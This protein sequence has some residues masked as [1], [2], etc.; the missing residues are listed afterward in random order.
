MG[1]SAEIL[2]ADGNAD[3]DFRFLG[4]RTVD[5]LGEPWAL[6]ARFLSR[7][8]AELSPNCRIRWS[9]GSSDGSWTWDGVATSVVSR[10]FD[11]TTMQHQVEAL[12]F[13]HSCLHTPRRRVVQGDAGIAGLLHAVLGPDAVAHVDELP[14]G[15]SL[16][17]QWIQCDENDWDF[18]ERVLARHGLSLSWFPKDAL[19]CW[20][21]LPDCGEVLK[22][23][24]ECWRTSELLHSPSG[25][26]LR[27]RTSLPGA[28]AGRRVHGPDDSD[29]TIVTSVAEV[30]LEGSILG[31]G[32][33][34]PF[35]A[36]LELVPAGQGLARH[37]RAPMRPLLAGVIAA[38]PGG[39]TQAPCQ[40]EDGSYMVLLAFQDGKEQAWGRLRMLQA[41]AAPGGGVAWSLEP[42]TPVLLG[43]EPTDPDALLILGTLPDP[44]FPSPLAG[45]TAAVHTLRSANGAELRIT[46]FPQ[47]K[48]RIEL[49]SPG[50][51]TATLDDGAQSLRLENS[52]LQL[53]LDAKVGTLE[54]KSPKASLSLTKEGALT[55]RAEHLHIETKD[56]ELKCKESFTAECASW[57]VSAQG[58]MKLKASLIHL[59]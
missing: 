5:H 22:L 40:H 57:E 21:T 46:D 51:I 25:K 35:Q 44:E 18:L 52:M 30:S 37:T 58:D 54:L 29:W 26:S 31:C 38:P 41:F 8:G 1:L 53:I 34:L 55:L 12:P 47:A 59:N 15:N 42:G 45:I 7:A 24:A 43:F 28:F 16:P 56:I 27:L 10:Q 17:L 3:T 49:K 9:L 2:R 6:T 48:A 4:G 23:P 11:G 19:R 33:A 50:G 20:A 36:E 14:P 32:P 13:P 39:S